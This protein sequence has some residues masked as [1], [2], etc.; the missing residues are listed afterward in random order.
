LSSSRSEALGKRFTGY[1]RVPRRG[2]RK[3]TPSPFPIFIDELNSRR[4][5]RLTNGGFV[6]RRNRN[7]SV[8]YLDAANCCYSDLQVSRTWSFSERSSIE[9]GIDMFRDE[10]AMSRCDH[11]IVVCGHFKNR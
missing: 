5:K 4:F 1:F 11:M 6:R 7:F 8:D 2:F 10:F 9:A 3:R